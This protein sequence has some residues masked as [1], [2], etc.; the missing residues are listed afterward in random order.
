M[1]AAVLSFLTASREHGA[2][3]RAVGSPAAALAD[4][5]AQTRYRREA[6]VPWRFD[7]PG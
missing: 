2:C 5:C 1:P 3:N 4:H 6:G 7:A